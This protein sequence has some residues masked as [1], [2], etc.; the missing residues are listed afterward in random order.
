[1]TQAEPKPNEGEEI[2][3]DAELGDNPG[4]DLIGVDAGNGTLSSVSYG[5][6]YRRL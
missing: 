2:T 5:T 3:D 1:L 6:A 4:R